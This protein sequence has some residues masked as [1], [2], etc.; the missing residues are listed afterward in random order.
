MSKSF[1]LYRKRKSAR[2]CACECPFSWDAVSFFLVEGLPSQEEKPRPKFS[3]YP[4]KNIYRGQRARP[5]ITKEFRE[6]RTV[7][8]RGADSDVDFAGHYTVPRWGCGTDCNGFVIVDSISG[9]VY[10]GFGVAG[11]SPK[12]LENHGG[13]ELERMEFHPKSRLLKIDACPNEANCGF[14]DYVMVD[15]SGLKLIR[16]EL[17][18]KEFQ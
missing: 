9:K 5:I 1:S 10:S 7:I 15:G 17:L 16:K 8:R 4:V 2:I 14:Y 6:I 3:D 11:L 12:W 18:P 13:E